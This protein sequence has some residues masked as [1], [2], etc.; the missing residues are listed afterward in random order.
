MTKDS[1][2]REIL[3]ARDVLNP[4]VKDM[5]CNTITDNLIRCEI[6]DKSHI[7]FLYSSFRNEVDTIEIIE[8]CFKMGKKVALPVSY[9]SAGLPKMDFYFINSR[10]DLIA[11][12][13]GILEPDRRKM[14]VKKASALPDAIVVPG[15]A[16]D[17]SMNR[18]GYGAGFYDSYLH[19]N[20][21]DTSGIKPYL[22]GLCYDFQTGYDIT[23]EPND[24]KM[25]ILITENGTYYGENFK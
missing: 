19:D 18:I 21:Y 24:V 25:D 7:V 14:S 23:A 16:F 11:G 10:T 6:F 4:M 1:I 13:M 20:G 8:Y 9:M 5:L 15:V 12:Y 3:A 22:I 17:Y 2:R